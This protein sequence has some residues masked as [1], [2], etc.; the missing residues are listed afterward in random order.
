MVNEN[1]ECVVIGGSHAGLSAALVLGR[2]LRRTLVIDA[3]NP[4]NRPSR[5]AHNFYSRD[6]QNPM[7]LIKLGKEQLTP[8]KTVECA[9]GVVTG[10]VALDEGFSVEFDGRT[11]SATTLILATGASD[12]MRDVPGYAELWGSRILHCPYCHGF[13]A[14]GSRVGYVTPPGT[15]T[16]Y[17]TLLTHWYDDL[18]MFTNG[19]EF[20]ADELRRC[21]DDNV[22]IVDGTIRSLT[23][24]GGGITVTTDAEALEVGYLFWDSD[25]RYNTELTEQLG[26]ALVT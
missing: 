15:I 1:Y 25:K 22:R 23:K 18:V 17:N 8:Y 5:E 10:V 7:D 24:A 26:C 2:S 16:K 14:I 12:G 6:G 11:L 9:S 20:S 21:A 13:E 3:D 19:Q 4:R